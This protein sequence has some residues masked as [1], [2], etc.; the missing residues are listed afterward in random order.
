MKR[1]VVLA[2]SLAAVVFGCWAWHAWPRPERLFTVSYSPPESIPKEEM[3]LVLFGDPEHPE[4]QPGLLPQ[5]G[6]EGRDPKQVLE[7]HGVTFPSGADIKFPALE[8]AEESERKRKNAET[9]QL[10]SQY[11]TDYYAEYLFSGM[12]MTNTKANHQRLFDL[13]KRSFADS[14]TLGY[15][16]LYG[17]PSSPSGWGWTFDY[18]YR[19]YGI[20]EWSFCWVVE[21]KARVITSTNVYLAHGKSE[22]L[23]RGMYRVGDP[24]RQYFPGKKITY[25]GRS[26]PLFL[27]LA[28]LPLIFT[29]ILRHPL[30]RL[31]FWKRPQ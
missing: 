9:D 29:Y 17:A 16:P 13:L 3:R 11:F 26:W 2:S 19:T 28:L 8:L 15:T 21:G 7:S 5:E 1:K 4:D 24:P 14:A 23:S 10:G 12:E 22:F 27:G 30:G 25:Q 31:L 20:E 18:R 6:L